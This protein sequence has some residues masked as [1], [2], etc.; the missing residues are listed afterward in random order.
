MRNLDIRHYARA[1]D[2]PLWMI[3][4]ELN[5]SESSMTRKL[6]TELSVSEKD[7]IKAIINLLS[8]AIEN[9]K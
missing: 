5:I 6:R 4:Q 7:R 3:A 1:R 9:N 8:Q 2:V